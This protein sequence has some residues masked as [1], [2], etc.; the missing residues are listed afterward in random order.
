M[1]QKEIAKGV[2]LLD[3][4]QPDWR[5]EINLSTLDMGSNCYCVLGQLYGSYSAGADDL[6]IDLDSEDY[7]FELPLSNDSR[8]ATGYDI[9][10]KEWKEA[11]EGP[12]KAQPT[13]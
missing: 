11:I 2:K 13:G 12:P 9:L 10:T 6:A 1:F 4:S 5:D 7:G 8:P 3:Q